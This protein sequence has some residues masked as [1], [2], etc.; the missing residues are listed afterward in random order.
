MSTLGS[1]VSCQYQAFAFQRVLP[2]GIAFL[3]L[4]WTQPKLGVERVLR[5]SHMQIRVSPGFAIE[6]TWQHGGL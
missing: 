3:A 4:H 2:D 1:G 6:H 5:G